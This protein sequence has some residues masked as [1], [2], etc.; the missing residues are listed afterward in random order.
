MSVDLMDNNL[1]PSKP[2]KVEKKIENVNN[3]R[4]IELEEGRKQ[5]EGEGAGVARQEP[6]NIQLLI[7]NQNLF[8]ELESKVD[9]VRLVEKQVREISTLQDTFSSKVE[10]QADGI[11]SLH[12]IAV[13]S[14]ENVVKAR[15]V[16]ESAN[17]H[18]SDL[19]LFILVLIYSFTVSL[20][21]THIYN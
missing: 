13:E 14:K 21:F 11:E 16:L 18:G 17:E 7:E 5:D 1:S 2:D 8:E 10:E 19:R 20:Y 6:E 15:N 3:A 9:K 4:D 12:Q